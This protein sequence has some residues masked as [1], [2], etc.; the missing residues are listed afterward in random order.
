M[1]GAPLDR[2]AV[3]QPSRPDL[4]ENLGN[5][6]IGI[7][8]TVGGHQVGAQGVVRD[9]VSLQ[10]I[11]ECI[12]RDLPEVRMTLHQTAQPGV[13]ELLVAPQ[14]GDRVR[15]LAQP[16]AQAR[17]RRVNVE[18]C[19]VGVEDAG[20]DAVEGAG[21]HPLVSVPGRSPRLRS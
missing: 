3:F 20:L 12:A 2:I 9:A 15:L 18:K 7:E 4:F 13:L 19:A 5:L 14:A 16:P 21:A 11:V 8:R 1:A 10:G 17:G 6:R